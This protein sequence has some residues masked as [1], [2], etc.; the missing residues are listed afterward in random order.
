MKPCVLLVQLLRHDTRRVLLIVRHL[1][2]K[3]LFFD[4]LGC[5]FALR[6]FQNENILVLLLKG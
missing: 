4:G 6:H 5:R 1:V 3:L 2:G